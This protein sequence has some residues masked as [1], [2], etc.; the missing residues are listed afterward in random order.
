MSRAKA[1]NLPKRPAYYASE[2]HA[3]STDNS[4]ELSR[5]DRF[6]DS[7]RQLESSATEYQE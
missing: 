1:H 5:V 2:M 4:R 6:K 7:K 3:I